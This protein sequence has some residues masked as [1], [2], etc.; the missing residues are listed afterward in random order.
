MGA[1]IEF[2]RPEPAPAKPPDERVVFIAEG[3]REIVAMYV[4]HLDEITR[5]LFNERTTANERQEFLNG[6]RVRLKLEPL[7]C[8]EAR[9]GN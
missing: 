6:W 5:Y 8:T 7:E 3:G 1:V 9:H 2:K 4:E